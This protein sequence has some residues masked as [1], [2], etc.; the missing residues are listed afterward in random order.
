MK[1]IRYFILGMAI[2]SLSF[3]SLTGLLAQ[4]GNVA[5]L[6][7]YSCSEITSLLEPGDLLYQMIHVNQMDPESSLI[8][9]CPVDKEDQLWE[10]I[11]GKSLKKKLPADVIFAWGAKQQ[12]G[13]LPLYALKR[14]GKAGEGP[15]G[16]DI[17]QVEVVSDSHSGRASLLISFSGKGARK[18][19]TLT[20]KNIG[21]D[22]AIVVDDRVWSAPRVQEQIS[23]GKCM[24]TGNFTETEI[25]ALKAQLDPKL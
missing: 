3:G 10:Y 11:Q 14:A 4:D 20:G 8:G 19:A 23:M 17:D 21:R 1:T 6:E 24:I 13:E 22:I 2:I 25:A 5:F 18:W 15:V 12:E 7:T 16:P 9:N